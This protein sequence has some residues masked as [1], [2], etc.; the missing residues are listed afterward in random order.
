MPGRPS[1]SEDPASAAFFEVRGSEPGA[2]GLGC[3]TVQNVGVWGR[4][5]G[6]GLCSTVNFLSLGFKVSVY[7][8]TSR[9]RASSFRGSR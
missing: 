9:L 8:A 6:L 3:V 2:E 5:W 7:A 1:G 4:V